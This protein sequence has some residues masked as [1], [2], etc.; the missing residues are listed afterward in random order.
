MGERLKIEYPTQGSEQFLAYRREILD[1][2]DQAKAKTKSLAVCIPPCPLGDGAL[3]SI[4]ARRAFPSVSPQRVH[5]VGW[6][7]ALIYINR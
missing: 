1:A 2:Y 6:L 3:P 4:S 7:A 5:S